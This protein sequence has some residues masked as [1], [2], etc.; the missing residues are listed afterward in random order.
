MSVTGQNDIK[1]NTAVEICSSVERAIR[2]EKLGPGDALPTVRA[3]AKGLTVSPA[4]VSSAYRMLRE[5][6]LVVARGR[7]GTR[8]A[9]RPPVAARGPAPLPAGVVDLANGNPDPQLLPDPAEVLGEIRPGKHLY[10]H[11]VNYEP[12][13]RAFAKRFRDD[14]IPAE[15]M[16]VVS[17]ALDGLE[18]ALAAHLR[19]GDRVAVEDPAFIGVLD[20]LQALG[21]VAVPMAIDAAG[22]KPDTLRKVLQSGVEAVIVTPRAQNPTGAALDAKR[23]RELRAVLRDYPG[24][25][26]LEDDHAGPVSGVDAFTL[27]DTRRSRWAIVRSVSKSLG[28]DL[29]VAVLTGDATTVARVEG[30]TIIG[31]RWVSHVLQRTVVALLRRRGMTARLRAAERAYTA[32]RDAVVAALAERGIAAAGRSGLNVWVPVRDEAETVSLLLERGWAVNAGQRFRI[33]SGPAIRIC[34]AALEPASA[35]ALADAVAQVVRPASPTSQV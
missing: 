28:P 16:V 11:S 5:R 33:E 4:T 22:P 30:G 35:P 18:R 3:L 27:C 34:V 9:G 24:V 21:L 26:I 19:A 2:R 15:H 10:G 8:V 7:N 6:G 32:R 31:M 13:L 12:L 1:G 14:G 17:G 29:R 23:A 25:L 20:L